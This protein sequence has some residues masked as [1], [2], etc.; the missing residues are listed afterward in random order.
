MHCNYNCKRLPEYIGNYLPNKMVWQ[1]NKLQQWTIK[2]H[3]QLLKQ[4]NNQET[5]NKN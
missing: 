1:N 2:A 3:C 4:G 5:S